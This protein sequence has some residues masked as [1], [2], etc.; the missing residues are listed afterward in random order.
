[1]RKTH[2]KMKRTEQEKE[3][4]AV[5][6]QLGM[7]YEE[8]FPI[9]LGDVAGG[10]GV[11][12]EDGVNWIVVDFLVRLKQK[13][14]SEIV[15]GSKNNGNQQDVVIKCA[16]LTLGSGR[17]RLMMRI[18]QRAHDLELRFFEIKRHYGGVICIALMEAPQYGVAAYIRPRMPDA[19]IVV[20]S[21]DSLKDELIRLENRIEEVCRRSLASR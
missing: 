19:D 10:P 2:K 7:D 20:D 14:C 8:Q 12:L 13:H 9:M 15:A 3:V 1:L 11:R 17:K 4:K 5:L 16:R 6:D 21:V 18:R